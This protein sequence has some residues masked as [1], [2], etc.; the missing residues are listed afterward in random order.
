MWCC[1]LPSA[2]Q[3][4]PSFENSKTKF[5]SLNVIQKLCSQLEFNLWICIFSGTRRP[6]AVFQ[7]EENTMSIPPSRFPF[8]IFAKQI[9]LKLFKFFSSKIMNLICAEPRA[10]IWL[11]EEFRN[12]GE[13]KQDQVRR[14]FYTNLIH[15][16]EKF[17][18]KLLLKKFIQT[19]WE[20]LKIIHSKSLK[21]RG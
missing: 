10:R 3:S 7:E 8:H 1:H 20:F 13:D 21:S 9:F 12:W 2:V 11:S 4:R 6:R 5:S 16:P 17:P 19:N 18:F 15:H 14:P